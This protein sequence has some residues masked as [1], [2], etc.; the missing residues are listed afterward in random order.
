MCRECIWLCKYHLSDNTAGKHKVSCGSRARNYLFHHHFLLYYYF[1]MQKDNQGQSD[2]NKN[3]IPALAWSQGN[4]IPLQW[5]YILTLQ[6][7]IVEEF[8][9]R[10]DRKTYKKPE[11][12]SA[13]PTDFLCQ[14]RQ[15]W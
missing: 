7:H 2:R 15:P 13:M 5:M 10:H 14:G 8:V 6:V 11:T 1:L 12:H 3:L 4:V 9:K